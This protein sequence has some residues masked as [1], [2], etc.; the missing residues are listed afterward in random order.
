MGKVKFTG[1]SLTAIVIV[2][3][4]GSL[5]TAGIVMLIRRGWRDTLLVG[6]VG[7]AVFCLSKIYD[8]V[9]K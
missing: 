6:V 7:V 8:R 1:T 2:G 5:A 9:V 4:L 3:L